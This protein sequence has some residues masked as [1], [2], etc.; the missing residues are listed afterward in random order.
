MAS[1]KRSRKELLIFLNE[2]IVFEKLMLEKAKEVECI[3]GITSIKRKRSSKIEKR[4]AKLELTLAY[5]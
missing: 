3:F 4:I 2:S 1:K 5:I